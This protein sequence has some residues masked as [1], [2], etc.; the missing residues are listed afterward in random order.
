MERLKHFHFMNTPL[1]RGCLSA[2]RHHGTSRGQCRAWRSM[3]GRCGWAGAERTRGW[4]W[5]T[6]NYMMEHFPFSAQGLFF[7]SGAWMRGSLFS[8]SSTNSLILQQ[9]STTHRS[10][11]RLGAIGAADGDGKNSIPRRGNVQRRQIGRKSVKFHAKSL[12]LHA[13]KG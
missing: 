8:F 7:L 3:A 1:G 10:E 13:V 5:M 4:G 2:P 9:L 6:S 11:N 12:R